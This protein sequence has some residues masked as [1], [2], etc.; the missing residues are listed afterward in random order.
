MSGSVV[1]VISHG[2][3]RDSTNDDLIAR[4]YINSIPDTDVQAVEYIG[5]FS[6]IPCTVFDVP[7]KEQLFTQGNHSGCGKG[8]P[9]L[10]IQN[11]LNTGVQVILPAFNWS[12]FNWNQIDQTKPSMVFVHINAFGRGC[13]HPVDKNLKAKLDSIK[14]LYVVDC[15]HDHGSFLDPRTDRI[16][17]IDPTPPP[18]QYCGKEAF[19][20]GWI[21]IDTR[22]PGKTFFRR[23]QVDPYQPY[24]GVPMDWQREVTFTTT[25]P[26]IKYKCSGP[27][28][29]QCIEDPNG[30]FNTLQE[31]LDTCK[32][33][34]PPIKYRCSGAPDYQCVEDP[35]GPYSSLQACIDACKPTPPPIGHNLGT[36]FYPWFGGNKKVSPNTTWRHWKNGN[37][38]PPKTWASNYLPDCKNKFEPEDELYSSK[39]KS[40][41]RWQLSNMKRAHIDF[42][43]SSWWGQ[44]SY[45]DQ[46][47]DIIFNKVLSQ[48]DNPYPD[49]KFCIYY[50]KEGTREVPLEEIISDIEYIKS[51]YVN[52]PY[53][54]QVNNKPVVFVFNAI[55]SAGSRTAIKWNEVRSQTNIF[56]VLK[57]YPNY[58][59]QASMSDSWHQYGP[60]IP[61]EQQ[62]NYSAYVSPGYY[63]YHEKPKLTREDF[64]RFES[65]VA[66]LSQAN[67]QFRLIET[68]NEYE[69]A[70]QIEPAQKIH[71]DDKKKFTKA[72][73]SYET[74]YLDILAKYFS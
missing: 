32:P 33:I 4:D 56:T 6:G 1:N 74:R 20:L 72:A 19:L 28:D 69:E 15:G 47:L 12:S 73:D 48:L 38:H 61:F 37:H 51:K 49:V 29:Y 24:K 26:P 9:N 41:I 5:D 65:N 36:F 54:F 25:P 40:V 3:M 57:V 13:E 70:T 64:I 50:E 31:C 52:S 14:N 43:I 39:S 7:D 58:V 34:P 30:T 62:S 55:E 63:K 10:F 18:I 45:E 59:N 35:L 17:Y 23:T 27:P 60:T 44:N 66:S 42:A 11:F 21:Q 2:D 8:Q 46:A 71:H 53:Y 68:W 67:V 22:T 16:Y